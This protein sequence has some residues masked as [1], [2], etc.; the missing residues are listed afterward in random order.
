MY[1][2]SPWVSWL[3]RLAR[4]VPAHPLVGEADAPD[5]F[6][7]MLGRKGAESEAAVLDALREQGRTIIDL[8]SVKGSPEDRVA[9][10]VAALAKSP[11]VIYQA[12]LLS[13]DFFGIADFLVRVGAASPATASSDPLLD[14]QQAMSPPP[15]CQY[16]VWDAKLARSPR[17]SQVLQ[18]CCYA[19]MLAA[20]QGAPVERVGLILGATPLVLRTASFGSIYRRTRERFL[21]AQRHFE[22]DDVPL[23]PEPRAP[24]GRW[25][26]IADRQ[27]LERDDLRLVARVSRRQ[28]ARLQAA[29]ISTWKEL[30]A[31][32]GTDPRARIELDVPGM[33]PPI[34]RRLSRQAQLQ[35][36]AR[37]NPIQPPPVELLGGACAP[38]AALGALP[39]PHPADCFFDLEGYPFATLPALAG[40]A[41]SR[42]A[43]LVAIS[44]PGSVVAAA[45]GSAG[46][47]SGGGGADG[48]GGGREYLWGIS[49]R[50][51][52]GQTEYHAWWAH[53]PE[54][55][56]HAFAACV[57]WMTS[58]I[59][60]RPGMHVY[61]FGA[62][63]L[64]VLRRLAGRYG[65]RESEVDDLLRS[66]RL[67]T[68]VRP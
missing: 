35:L 16:V 68:A 7:Q 49:T 64:S 29:G 66:V 11:E 33:P 65:T 17:P 2:E 4:E 43:D 44:Q 5:A 45:P 57:D 47:S 59:R 31:L 39:P 27:M 19:E 52:S 60:S 20:L 51:V 32:T 55:E 63:E 15:P 25:S 48:E 54:E 34:L 3:E 9:A 41:S 62:Y 50:P 1:A 18:L 53:S 28:A 26:K 10:T 46:A 21:H 36:T 30:A 13:D 56:R 42:L 23:P 67:D 37:A 12:P 8:S 58:R 61:H 14:P 38:G 24:T 22:P 40:D 6:L